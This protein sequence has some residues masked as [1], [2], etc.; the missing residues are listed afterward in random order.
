MKINLFAAATAGLLTIALAGAAGASVVVASRT[1]NQFT[2]DQGVLLDDFD[3]FVAANVQF[4]GNTFAGPQNP[5]STAAEPPYVPLNPLD[6][7][8]TTICCDSHGNPY[9]ADA[10]GFESVEGGQSSTFAAINGN[11]LT[12][13]N[14]YMGSPDQYNH[15]IFNFVGGGSQAFDGD[16]IWGGAPNGNGDRSIGFRVYYDF[17]GAHVSSIT[18]TSDQNAF[19]ADNFGGAVVPE[20]AS[21]A[22]M[23]SGFG[24]AGGM[25]RAKR[26]RAALA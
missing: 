26:R 18:F 1:A 11:Y 9:S 8:A 24:L 20:P 16:A 21:W 13:F 23:L 19:E 10:T 7:N 12:S 6:P 25:L 17:N 14:F 15:V 22:L 2:V 4:T 5:V 3:G